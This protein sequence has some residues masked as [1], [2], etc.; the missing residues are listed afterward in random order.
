MTASD[1]E[2]GFS[3]GVGYVMGGASRSASDAHGCRGAWDCEI[4]GVDCVTSF[5]DCVTGGGEG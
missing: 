3:C 2:S 5:E 4:V 1:D